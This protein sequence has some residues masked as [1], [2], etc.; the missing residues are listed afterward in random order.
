VSD[1]HASGDQ[2]IA[3]IAASI[4]PGHHARILG[5]QNIKGTGLDFAY[6]WVGLQQVYERLAQLEIEN[7]RSDTLTWLMA[8]GDYGLLD[9]RLALETLRVIVERDD[10]GWLPWRAEL[11]ATTE[12]LERVVSERTTRLEAT[13]ARKGWLEGLLGRVEPFLDHLDSIRRFRTA[14]RIMADLGAQRVGQAQAG[15]LLRDLV[16]RGKGGWLAKDWRASR[17]ARRLRSAASAA[18]RR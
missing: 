1:S 13:T 12:H 6:R 17:D 8:Y 18:R 16:A 7:T 14:K 10:A 9:A 15:R 3:R 5:C 4:P 2:V 11:C